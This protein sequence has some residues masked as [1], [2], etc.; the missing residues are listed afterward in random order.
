MPQSKSNP[1]GFFDGNVLAQKSQ[2]SAEQRA[3]RQIRPLNSELSSRFPL[4]LLAR[5]R[6]TQPSAR[7][8]LKSEKSM[9]EL[10]RASPNA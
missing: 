6:H 10:A 3:S 2:P 1:T 5:T 8:P 7:T 9:T 4:N